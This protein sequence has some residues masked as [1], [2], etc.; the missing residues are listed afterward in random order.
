[1]SQSCLKLVKPI[2]YSKAK[3]RRNI[4]FLLFDLPYL[5][6]FSQFESAFHNSVSAQALRRRIADAKT[7][8][9]SDKIDHNPILP[10]PLLPLSG[11]D[12]FKSISTITGS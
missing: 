2:H 7:K 6:T 8:P 10:P 11:T 3:K 9:I 4:I 1:M 12:S 5:F